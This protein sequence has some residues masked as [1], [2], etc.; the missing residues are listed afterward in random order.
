MRRHAA[1][2]N[3]HDGAR[4]ERSAKFRE[5]RIQRDGDRTREARSATSR[6]LSAVNFRVVAA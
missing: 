1:L 6:A 2:A 3:V 4:R 5:A